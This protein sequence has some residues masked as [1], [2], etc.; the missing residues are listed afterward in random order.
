MSLINTSKDLKTLCTRLKKSE[1]VTVDTEFIREKTYWARLCLIQ[2]AGDDE[3]AFAIDPLA[4]GIDLEPFYDLM[5]NKDILKVFHAIN[6]AASPTGRS[7]R[8]PPSN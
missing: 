6:P 2:V 5:L 1:F 7:G 3:E 8:F 4:E